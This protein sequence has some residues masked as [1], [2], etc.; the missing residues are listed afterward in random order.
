MGR[1]KRE[2][3][4][5]DFTKSVQK[6][7]RSRQSGVCACCG[8]SLNDQWE[9][10]HHVVP[11]QCGDKN[12]PNH[13]WLRTAVNCVVLCDGCHDQVHGENKTSGAVAPPDYYRFSHS[14]NKVQHKEWVRDL[15]IKA[16]LLW[17]AKVRIP[18]D[19]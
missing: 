8:E 17:A 5:F 14:G 13:E 11:N 12:N 10:A 15:N 4:P 1:P 18:P 6:E 9:E 7:A 3:R 2:P 19:V 16:A